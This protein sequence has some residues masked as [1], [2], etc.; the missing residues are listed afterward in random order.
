M[1]SRRHS[2]EDV[3]NAALELLNEDGLDAVTIR[4]VARRMRVNVNTVSFQVG[5][6]AHLLGLMS[7][8][9]L[10]NLSLDGLP[11]D[12]F[13]RVEEALRRYRSTL[14]MYRDGARLT[15]GNTPFE[16]HTRQFAEKLVAALVMAGV[17]DTESVRG[18]WAL[19]YFL[20]GI[21]QEQQAAQAHASEE[22]LPASTFPTLHRLHSEVFSADFDARY[23][24]GVVAILAHLRRA[25]S[26][27]RGALR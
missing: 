7:D 23:E 1:P 16:E 22:P 25:S 2:R 8:A 21:T 11:T 5:T 19:F 12:G 6:K 10:A 24:F 3:I 4:E 20:L 15:A 14:L 17:P 13:Q 9:V 26:G 18:M 27:R